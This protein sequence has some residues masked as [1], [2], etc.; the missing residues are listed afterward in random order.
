MYFLIDSLS[1]KLDVDGLRDL[2]SREPELFYGGF[3]SSNI[4]CICSDEIIKIGSGSILQKYLTM[5]NFW[6][7]LHD[8]WSIKIKYIPEWLT[9]SNLNVET[10][11]MKNDE[12][13]QIIKH[14]CKFVIE[15]W[16]KLNTYNQPLIFTV[17][18]ILS[19]HHL[20]QY[21]YDLIYENGLDEE[22]DLYTEDIFSFCTQESMNWYLEKDLINDEIR[23]QE[24]YFDI[25]DPS[26]TINDFLSYSHSVKEKGIKLIL[27]RS[28]ELKK[29]PKHLGKYFIKGYLN[30]ENCTNSLLLTI[31]FGLLS[32]NTHSEWFEKRLSEEHHKIIKDVI[33]SV[34]HEKILD[35]INTKCVFVVNPRELIKYVV[36]HNIFFPEHHHLFYLVEHLDLIVDMY[37]EINNYINEAVGS[38]QFR[39]TYMTE[40]TLG[41]FFEYIV[42]HSLKIKK[43]DHW[44]IFNIINLL[45][46]PRSQYLYFLLDAHS[47]GLFH[48][49]FSEFLSKGYPKNE[50]TYK[51]I[52][53]FF[54][55]N[56]IPID[57]EKC[58]NPEYIKEQLS[59]GFTDKINFI[60][61][62]IDCCLDVD[63]IVREYADKVKFIYL[64]Y[65][66]IFYDYLVSIG[67]HDY[68]NLLI[69]L[70]GYDE[71]AAIAYNYLSYDCKNV[72]LS[73]KQHTIALI[74]QA[75]SR[76]ELYLNFDLV[77]KE[78]ENYL[79]VLYVKL[80]ID[81]IDI[82]LNLSKNSP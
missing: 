66:L 70:I 18:N 24:H 45:V 52:Y 51:D 62:Y 54:R 1:I 29:Y 33:S 72:F 75:F 65:P 64:L 42:K 27:C 71:D 44:F 74:I 6:F 47:L 4:L 77:K 19:N 79:D 61:V 36:T 2:F 63:L 41:K 40:D 53:D 31:F 39:F 82:F 67:H 28:D 20:L 60:K 26:Y 12:K 10:Q 5:L 17:P 14:I 57:Q 13:N 73:E 7:E 22:I 3:Y 81:S 56:S 8:I 16:H 35:L 78:F 11:E 43:Y 50:H 34:D 49:N 80:V 55:S 58:L 23:N 15:R 76:G 38:T 9:L 25:I 32:D 69:Y 46:L 21:I 68:T 48:L 30:Q 37:P 59:Y